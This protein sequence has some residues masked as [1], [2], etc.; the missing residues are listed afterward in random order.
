MRVHA[1]NR[2]M[3][4]SLAQR[5]ITPTSFLADG[6]GANGGAKV[7]KLPLNPHLLPDVERLTQLITPRSRILAL[8]QMSNVTGGCPDLA[9]AIT[10]AHAAGMVVMVDGARGLC[11]TLPMYSSWILISMR[12]QA[13]S[14]MAPPVLA[15]CTVSRNCWKPCLHWLGGG[16]MISEVSFDGFTTQ[17]APW[18][19][20]AGTPNVAGVI[21]LSA[22][23]EWLAD[24]DV[25]QAENWSRGLATLA[26]DAW[27][28]ALAFVPSAA[29]TPVC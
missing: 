29:R 23:L 14:Y 2:V 11:I 17:P 16:K 22:A 24:V 10:L 1:Y 6:R 27:R 5:N 3:R 9:R 4:L 20:E 8:G 15:C 28:N 25:A 21:G 13:T 19:L 12:F 7:V 18:K 26:E